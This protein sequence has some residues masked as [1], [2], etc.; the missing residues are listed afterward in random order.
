MIYAH[1]ALLLLSLT[2]LSNLYA[3]PMRE[4]KVASIF[5]SE[6]FINEQLSGHLAKSDLVQNLKMKLDPISGKM[7]LQGN[8]Q[9]P[10][11]DLRAVGIEKDLANFKFQLSIHPK[12]SP[13]KHLI[14]EFPLSET[15]F[16][17]ANSKNPKRDR[18]VIPVQ[19]LYLGLA[20]TRGYLAA[21]SGDF[22]SFDRKI[23]K[24]K[25]LL[26]IANRSILVEKNPDALA[27]LKSS[28][29]SLELQIASTE[30]EHENFAR[31][32]KTL[33]TIFAFTGEKEFNL[34]NE[35]RARGNAIMLKLKLS[36]LV[37]YLKDVDL[38]DIRVG[39][40]NPDNSGESF[41]IFDINTLVSEPPVA[42]KKTARKAIHYDIPPTLMIRLSQDLFTSKLMM[43]KGKATSD[44]KDF[45]VRFKES[46]VHIS[47]KVHKF[48]W[49]IPFEGLV[50]FT[51]ASPDVFEVR[52]RKMKVLNLDL[53]F[54]TPLI[55]T[56]V[57]S[58]LKKALK[59]IATYK[60]LGDKDHSR[61]LQVTILPDKLVP[62]YPEF[63]LTGVDVR[64]RSFML[65]IGRIK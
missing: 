2:T 25:A 30:L 38:G 3:Q 24:Y 33:N 8:F 28:K 41:L 26:K 19:L 20:A 37:P 50:D 43:E 7:F 15:Y 5:I 63:H 22:S 4:S 10:L 57:K 13:N 44:L 6:D 11:D 23:A 32:A 49:D 59:G 62:A 65:K 45:K 64:D 36:K 51:Y 46:G 35:I 55:L 34:N 1:F 31:T 12:I 42:I 39:N 18:V 54:M 27:V 17:Q 56:A 61:V 52:L 29:K 58:R 47:G 40:S 9:L 21:L 48:F 53:K 60:Y 14:L 16:Y